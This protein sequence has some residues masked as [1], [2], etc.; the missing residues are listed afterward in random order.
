ML[1]TPK[2]Q[3]LIL[4]TDADA[5]GASPTP[6]TVLRQ[7]LH[8]LLIFFAQ[9]YDAVFGIDI[10]PPLHDP[11]AVA[12]LLSNLNKG[13]KTPLLLFHDN[14][15]ERFL[16]DVV[17]DSIHGGDIV[18]TGQLGRTLAKPIAQPEMGGVTIPRSVDVDKFWDIILDC[19]RRADKCNTALRN[20]N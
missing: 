16:V 13:R 1:A 8:A 7:I 14:E 19:L 12:V 3:S 10:G 18:L 20:A 11:V 6:P 5:A 4:Q 17:T 9:T 2:V 15:G